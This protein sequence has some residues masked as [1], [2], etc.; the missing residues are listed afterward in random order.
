M[1]SANTG[2]PV[3]QNMS[4]IEAMAD[5]WGFHDVYSQE[6]RDAA[7]GRHTVQQLNVSNSDPMLAGAVGGCGNYWR[8]QVTR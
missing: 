5:Q 7:L 8:C 4:V 6:D 1:E 3:Q 2:T